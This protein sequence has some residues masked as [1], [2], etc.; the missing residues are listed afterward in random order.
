MTEQPPFTAQ[1]VA[2]KKRLS[3]GAIVGIVIAAVFVVLVLPGL[4]L[5]IAIP[6]YSSQR[7][8]AVDADAKADVATIGKEVA[9]YF[10]DNTEPPSVEQVG[11]V[12]YIGN[13][14]DI[15]VPLSEGVNLGPVSLQSSSAWC[16]AVT[17]EGG[18]VGAFRYSAS[19]GLEAGTC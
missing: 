14:S 5:A 16:V 11:R 7:G 3:T 17:V 18:E 2:P 4:L 8:A 12:V 6:I 1:P 15:N 10:V 19:S 13:S 9:I